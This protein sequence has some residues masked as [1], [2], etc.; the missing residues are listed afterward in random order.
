MTGTIQVSSAL[1]VSFGS[2]KIA[3][4]ENHVNVLWSTFTEQNTDYFSVRKST[5]GIRFTEVGKV[6]AAG[7]STAELSYSYKDATDINRNK[8]LYYEIVTVDKD[9][10]ESHSEIKLVRTR[11]LS[12]ILITEIGPV[13]VTKPQ[14]LRVAFNA[15]GR[16]QMN[17]K[18]Y[19]AT[20]KLVLNNTM[21][22]FTG[23]NNAHLH[24]CDLPPGQYVAVFNLKGKKESKKIIIR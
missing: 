6:T 18:V 11:S 15:D 7:N 23:L 21:E 16:G 1:P 9:R 12:D 4:A 5:D 24:V 13:P 10:K 17:V 2:L 14:M 22:T 19:S 8:Y 3:A 20:G